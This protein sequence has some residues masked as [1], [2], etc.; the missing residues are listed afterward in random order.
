MPLRV[1][2]H[3]VPAP[4]T[5]SPHAQAF[6]SQRLEPTGPAQPS[7]TADKDA[8]RSYIEGSNTWLT[9]GLLASAEA[10]PAEVVTHRLPNTA[11]HEVVPADAAPESAILYLHGGAY[12][13]GAGLAGAYMAM[14]LAGH[15]RIRAF[16]VD[17]RM[18]PDHPFPAGLDDAVD[19]Y[20]WLLERYEPARIAFAGGSAGGGLA[21]ALALRVRDLGLP[22]PAACVLA[23]PEADLTESGDSFETLIHVDVVG[24]AR[25]TDS[26]SLYA[27]GHDLRD[28]YLSPLFGDF[29]RG[30]PPTLLTGG[31]RDLF[32]SNTVL[33]HRALRRAGIEAELDIWEAMPHGG[34]FGAPE[35]QEVLEV[36][37]RFLI[38]RL[39]GEPR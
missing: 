19:T 27:D 13:H 9:A 15:A 17:Y 35:D 20:R 24:G 26:I 12:L 2:E 11:L 14:P 3:N 33:M 6:L 36:Q 5:V 22:L 30:F 25:L 16:A 7:G 29:G 10:F 38:N 8:W 37:A 23:T 34:F 32:L 4:T 21:A 31:T 28:P 18:P 1:P 39:T